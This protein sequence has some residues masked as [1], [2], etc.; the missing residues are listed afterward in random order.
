MLAD[1]HTGNKKW[2]FKTLIKE[3]S[4]RIL[5]FLRISKVQFWGYLRSIDDHLILLQKAGFSKF[6]VGQHKNLKT[7]WLV[8]TL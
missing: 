6:Q 3:L 4:K 7:N 2:N 5:I 8:A 1:L